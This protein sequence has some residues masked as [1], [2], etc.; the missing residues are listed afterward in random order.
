MIF[1]NEKPKRKQT[2]NIKHGGLNILVVSLYI[3]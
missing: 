1:I 3:C 2:K